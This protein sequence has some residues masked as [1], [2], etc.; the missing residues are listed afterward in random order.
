M[1]T[2]A[3]LEESRDADR[4]RL[5]VAV[6]KRETAMAELATAEAQA[7]LAGKAFNMI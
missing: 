5:Y 1:A 4:L 2:S 3:L 6:A 7:R